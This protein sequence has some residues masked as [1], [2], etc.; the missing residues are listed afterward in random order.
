MFSLTYGILFRSTSSSLTNASISVTNIF[1]FHSLSLFIGSTNILFLVRNKV[2]I[3]F[4][5]FN[6][7]K[8]TNCSE[9]HKRFLCIS[10]HKV[11]LTRLL[12]L[13][14]WSLSF[15]Y[16]T[17]HLSLTDLG[18]RAK[19][20]MYLKLLLYTMFFFSNFILAQARKWKEGNGSHIETNVTHCIRRP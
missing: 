11:Q 6:E 18:F 2:V 19:I 14:R 10:V 20:C 4:L 13:K 5:F 9:K 7:C 12:K 17:R 16:L 15:I 3:F 8:A 1:F